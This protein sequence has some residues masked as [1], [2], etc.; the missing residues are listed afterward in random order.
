[1]YSYENIYY[2][3]IYLVLFS[4]LYKKIKKLKIIFLYVS[5]LVYTIYILQF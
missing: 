5:N 3:Y 2:I 1:M 4:T